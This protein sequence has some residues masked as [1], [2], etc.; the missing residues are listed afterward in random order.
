MMSKDK[1]GNF[2]FKEGKEYRMKIFVNPVWVPNS[3]SI[4]TAVKSDGKEGQFKNGDDI[5]WWYATD[6]FE[7]VK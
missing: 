6:Q 7:E 5:R 4:C 3:T 1:D 2:I